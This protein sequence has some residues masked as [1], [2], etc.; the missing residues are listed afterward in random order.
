M[1]SLDSK[2]DSK[3]NA[4]FF[5]C[6][7]CN[8]KCS[9][10]SNYNKHL[11]TLKHNRHFLDSKKCQKMPNEK[12]FCDCGKSYVY[13]TGYYRH[14]KKCKYK[15]ENFNGLDKDKIDYKG[16]LEKAIEENAKLI[17][18]IGELLPKIGNNN[19]VNNKQKININIFLHE[20][21]RDAISIDEFIDKIKVNI[22][23][24]LLTKNKGI[25]EGVSNIFIENI[26]KLSLYERPLH[27]TD[28]KRETVY[29]KNDKWEK[30]T[31]N[32]LFK[33]ALKKIGRV[34]QK[35]LDK[36]VT[37]HP[38]WMNNPEEQSDY[39]KL[40][41]TSTDDSLIKEDKI[42]KKVCNHIYVNE[43]TFLN[44]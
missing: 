10:K 19:I 4:E 36:W 25:N 27:C 24:L 15:K 38:N 13:D 35:S 43:D 1:D 28:P 6:K 40:I 21:C 12:W 41:N 22:D 17:G 26:N 20:Q 33:E 7:L 44:L 32:S 30:D 39:L 11:L 5:E 37:Q 3:K 8:F 23:N 29:I 9:K 16:M 14:K 2:M 42:I 18:H 34:Q 31:N